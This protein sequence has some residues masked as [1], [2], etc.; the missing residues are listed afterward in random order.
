MIVVVE[1]VRMRPP[2]ARRPHLTWEIAAPD[3]PS[4]KAVRAALERD[5]VSPSRGGDKLRFEV[6]DGTA[7]RLRGEQ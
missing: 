3:D 4:Y 2:G 5:F 7:T 6:V 1:A